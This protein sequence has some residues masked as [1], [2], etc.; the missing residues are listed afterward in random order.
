[1]IIFKY[2]W[3]E[4]GRFSHVG[5]AGGGAEVVEPAGVNAVAILDSAATRVSPDLNIRA[6]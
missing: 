3:L 5:F 2:K 4:R 1:M 6:T